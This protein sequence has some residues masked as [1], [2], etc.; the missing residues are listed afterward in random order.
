MHL[1]L[2]SP[3]AEMS[4]FQAILK[5]ADSPSLPPAATAPC[6]T[7][8]KFLTLFEEITGWK[9]EFIESKQRERPHVPP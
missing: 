1:D 8:G 2:N 9:V 3:S 7:T 5:L 4:Q 6:A